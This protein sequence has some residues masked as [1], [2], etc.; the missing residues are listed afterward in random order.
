MTQRP[1]VD[2]YDVLQ[3]SQT[4]DRETVERVYRLL[5]KRYHPDNQETGDSDRFAEVHEAYDVLSD[6]KRR[7]EYD[8][9]YDDNRGTQWKIF[10]QGMATDGREQDRRI[11][12]GVLSLL[13]AA[14]RR[15]PMY[16]GVGAVTLEKLLGVP[17]QHLEFPIWYLK[18]R[19]WVETMD[20]GQY[21]ITVEGIDKLGDRDMAVPQERLLAA[22]SVV[23]DRAR[24]DGVGAAAEPAPPSANGNGPRP[25]ASASA[26]AAGTETAPQP[27]PA[28]SRP[29]EDELADARELERRLRGVK[30]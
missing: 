15:D 20:N 2:Y 18:K 12:H 26:A 5:A 30:S 25:S 6:P 19:G 23:G 7:A 21:G 14:R 13:Y 9:R 16:G 1:F 17:R 27:Q 8:V 4:A 28:Q 22:S 11:F 3:L 29:G 10:D 24:G